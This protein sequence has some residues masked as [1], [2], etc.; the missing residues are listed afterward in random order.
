[1]RKWIN[2]FLLTTSLLIC[3]YVGYLFGAHS[4]DKEMYDLYHVY[5]SLQTLST[6]RED[7]ELPYYGMKQDVVLSMLPNPS[8]ESDTI[9]LTANREVGLFGIY[10]K[11]LERLSGSSDEIILKTFYW[12]FP[13]K[14]STVLFIVFEWVGDSVWIA[15]S[16]LQW[17]S[18]E[19]Y[20]D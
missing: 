15:N 16:C 1:M 13:D 19:M 4:R 5:D 2:I 7:A 12:S 9:R 8:V 10:D 6:I 17:K 3:L 14:D 20:L 18:N 11:F